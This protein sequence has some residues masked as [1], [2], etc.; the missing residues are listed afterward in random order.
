MLRAAFV[1][2]SEDV[3]VSVSSDVAPVLSKRASNALSNVRGGA[4]TADQS[5]QESP[6]VAPFATQATTAARRRESRVTRT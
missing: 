1:G 5:S 6:A 2:G 3:S 4:G